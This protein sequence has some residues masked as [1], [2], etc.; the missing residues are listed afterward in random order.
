M[1]IIYLHQYFNTPRMAGSIRSYEMARR[2]VDRGHEVHMVTSDRGDV[3]RS[4]A[5][6]ATTEEDGILVHWTHVPY[7]NHMSLERRLR[8][9]LTFSMRAASKAAALGGDVVFAT[10]TPLT[11]ALPALYAA[12]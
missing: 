1:K 5:K 10:S 7:S 6:W 8:A 2:L 9:F 11:I 3:P 12:W 4:T